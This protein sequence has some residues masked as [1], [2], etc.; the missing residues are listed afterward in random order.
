M[1]ASMYLPIRP[2]ALMPVSGFAREG[3]FQT[4]SLTPE[5][6]LVALPAQR[7]KVAASSAIRLRWLSSIAQGFFK[8]CCAISVSG[9]P[10]GEAD[11][12]CANAGLGAVADAIEFW[13]R[14]ART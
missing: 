13:I 2:L 12:H 6:A 14:R 8:P 10:G 1:N 7:W 5:T 9:V 4:K 3:T 11:V